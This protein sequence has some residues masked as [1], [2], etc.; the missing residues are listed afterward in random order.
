MLIHIHNCCFVVCSSITRSREYGHL[1]RITVLGMGYG[2]SFSPVSSHGR[3]RSHWEP[4]DEHERS[5]EDY[6]D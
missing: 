5:F 2:R 3:I 6:D 1:R 4:F